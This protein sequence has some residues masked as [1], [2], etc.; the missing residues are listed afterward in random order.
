[1]NNFL[2]SY[3]TRKDEIAKIF[4]PVN[5]D[6]EAARD[7]TVGAWANSNLSIEE[8]TFLLKNADNKELDIVTKHD[9]KVAMEAEPLKMGVITK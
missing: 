2:E 8:I 6:N 1:M 5:F 7:H 4:K 3:Y 9:L